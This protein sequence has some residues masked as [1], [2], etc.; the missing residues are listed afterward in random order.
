[1]RNIILI[2]GWPVLIAGSIVLVVKG[3]KVYAMV[4]DSLVGKVTKVLVITMLVEMYSLGVVC[5]SYLFTNL[6]RAV[7]VV[8]PIF[9]AWFA[10]FGIAFIT[11]SKVIKDTEK[12]TQK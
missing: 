9:V 5:T 7:F 12:L 8:L 4:K 1:M 6:D 3:R 11:I 10:V 2:I